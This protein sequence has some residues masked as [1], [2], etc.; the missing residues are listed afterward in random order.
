MQW[1][2]NC[3]R[4]FSRNQ[5]L[6]SQRDQ[7]TMMGGPLVDKGPAR[8]GRSWPINPGKASLG[9]NS[10]PKRLENAHPT[11][12][13]SIKGGHLGF[14]FFTPSQVVSSNTGITFT[15]WQL[16]LAQSNDVAIF[17]EEFQ[18]SRII[19]QTPLMIS[20]SNFLAN[21]IV[22][23]QAS[24]FVQFW[25][26]VE[27]KSGAFQFWSTITVEWGEVVHSPCAW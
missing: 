16:N 20:L 6:P 18:I 21:V 10:L 15:K 7:W 2:N 27:L 4:H 17:W 13:Y 1:R 22:S 24:K 26:K 9:N 14:R 25:Q 11:W 23:S 5:L 3:V 8:W 12:I 19:F